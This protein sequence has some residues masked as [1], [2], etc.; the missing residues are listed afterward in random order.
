MTDANAPIDWLRYW[1]YAVA[2]LTGMGFAVVD[3]RVLG[4]YVL[5]ALLLLIG[6]GG[7]IGM[8]ISPFTFGGGDHYMESLIAL[9][10]AGVALGG[11]VC[12]AAWHS[13]WK[14]RKSEAAE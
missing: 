9:V 8:N 6:A 1:P 13:V 5:G 12:A 2:L 10:A 11:Y 4:H 14:R 3:R 7:A